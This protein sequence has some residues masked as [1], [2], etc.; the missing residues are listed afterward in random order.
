MKAYNEQWIYNRNILEQA[1]QW[2][3]QTLLS[4]EQMT[5]V[6]KAY[7]VEFRQTNGF[8]EIGL[9][10]FTTVAILACYLLPASMFSLFSE[11]S[12]T[13]GVFNIAFGIAVG[14]V[15][16]LLINR[17]LLYRNGIDNA[18]VVTM[19]GFLAF[20]FNQF[21]PDGLSLS[22]HC[23]LTLPLLVL[24]L[25]YYGDTLIAFLTLATFYTAVFD[26]LLNYNWGKGALPFV[27]MSISLIIYVVVRQ[28]IIQNPK[29]VYYTDPLNLA[30]WIALIVLV[31][32]SNYFVVRELNGI[33]LKT[34]L[35]GSRHIDAPELGLPWLFWFL[36][37]GIPA[38]YVWQGLTKK[39]RMLII[40]GVLGL[41]AAVATAHE[42]TALVP[43]NVALT[44]GGLVLIG[45]AIVGVRYLRQPKYGFTDAPDDDSPNEFF[46]NAATATVVQATSSIHHGPKNDLRFGDGDFGG[47]GSE[48][49]Y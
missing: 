35:I 15:G 37:F 44:I 16:M 31:A 6:R 10:L 14:L 3:R 39:N 11:S 19:A 42:Y 26:G 5:A 21:L 47:A 20:G 2:H 17:R 7:P 36:T 40:L 28:V 18:F 13:Y 32:S 4:D 34:S 46:M 48:G 23:F 9:F 24:I 8:L 43:L 33:L 1:E 41:I 12:T 49:K 38:V 27:M 29:Q 45:I 25:W 22:V 30:Q